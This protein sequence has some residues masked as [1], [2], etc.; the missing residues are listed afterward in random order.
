MGAVI[1][2]RQNYDNLIEKENNLMK[3]RDNDEKE[4]YILSQIEK[5]EEEYKLKYNDNI[6][7]TNNPNFIHPYII[8]DIYIKSIQNQL[9]KVKASNQS[10]YLIDKDFRYIGNEIFNDYLYSLSD[11]RDEN[12]NFLERLN[13]DKNE[14]IYSQKIIYKEYEPIVKKFELY[15]IHFISKIYYFIF[16]TKECKTV[17]YYKIYDF[18]LNNQDI[19][20]IRNE[21]ITMYG[22]YYIY[23]V[24]NPLPLNEVNF[25]YYLKSIKNDIDFY[26]TVIDLIDINGFYMFSRKP[27]ICGFD[28]SFDNP[29]ELSEKNRLLT[30]PLMKFHFKI[31]KLIKKL[32]KI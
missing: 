25:E 14:F 13:L 10:I 24:H 19:D 4:N 5:Q 21:T 28:N 15:I 7:D 26:F 6:L 22:K 16:L 2:Q 1:I 31:E 9:K 20:K 8:F 27:C 3:Q 30:N 29:D 32:K 11:K 23:Y 18:Q 17:C 12:G